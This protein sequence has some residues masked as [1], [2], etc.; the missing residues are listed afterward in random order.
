MGLCSPS[1]CGPACG[2]MSACCLAIVQG[3]DDGSALFE[4]S[5]HAIVPVR[6]KR[7]PALSATTQSERGSCGITAGMVKLHLLDDDLA[8]LDESR[9][10]L[11]RVQLLHWRA[12][13]SASR[14]GVVTDVVPASFRR[15]SNRETYFTAMLAVL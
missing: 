13:M 5:F 4:P 6:P 9:Q 3:V 8:V 15:I 12:L 7:R 10:P 11:H 1:R 14:D 2:T